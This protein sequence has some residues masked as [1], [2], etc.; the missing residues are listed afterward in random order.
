MTNGPSHPL[1]Q[2]ARLRVFHDPAPLDTIVLQIAAELGVRPAQIQAAVDLLDGGA[3]VPFI[4]RYRKEVTEGLDDIQLR[5]LESRL[6]YL[7]ELEERRAAVLKS[8]DEQGKLTDALRAIIRA[9]PTKQELEDLYLPFK[10]KRRTKGMIAREAG[11]LPLADTLF[12]DPSLTPL[13][14]AAS[15][16]N[17]ELGFA[18]A[19][20]V[21]DGVRDLLSERW[22]EDALLIG[23]LREWLWA[24]ALFKLVRRH[25]QILASLYGDLVIELDFLGRKPPREPGNPFPVRQI[26]IERV[27]N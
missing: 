10:Q 19:Q 7:R 15:F 23:K 13:T 11:L 8:I 12:A 22:A 25:E 24:E 21:L 17:A 14:E 16:I 26:G 27:R 9:A 3:T 5:A 1:W 18:D 6:S 2:T 4:A 20:A